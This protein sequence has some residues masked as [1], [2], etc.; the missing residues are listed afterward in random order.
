[1][2]RQV[3]CFHFSRCF[4]A[5]YSAFLDG[6]F[7]IEQ[8]VDLGQEIKRVGNFIKS[9]KPTCTL[10]NLPFVFLANTQTL[11]LWECFRANSKHPMIPSMNA[12]LSITYKDLETEPKF[13]YHIQQNQQ[14]F[15]HTSHTQPMFHFPQPPNI[16]HFY[17]R[18]VFNQELSMVLMLLLFVTSIE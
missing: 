10:H 3:I 14:R 15:V 17:S 5:L 1:M 9:L 7:R 2:R 8:L 12:L 13:R 16:V 4:L 18:F 11:S 6:H